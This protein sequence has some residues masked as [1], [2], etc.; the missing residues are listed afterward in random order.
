MLLYNQTQIIVCC[1]KKCARAIGPKIVVSITLLKKY[2]VSST[3][4]MYKQWL[5]W[6]NCTCVTI[7]KIF[8]FYQG[9]SQWGAV[10]GESETVRES[11]WTV[12]VV[13]DY[14]ETKQ[15]AALTN[16]KTKPNKA[17][18]PSLHFEFSPIRLLSLSDS[19]KLLPKALKDSARFI[20]PL[21]CVLIGTLL[22]S[23]CGHHISFTN[24]KTKTNKVSLPR[25]HFD[26]LFQVYQAGT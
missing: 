12:G 21:G 25:L 8:K 23:G 15:S 10:S 7:F 18:L 5:L 22:Y 17:Y 6:N 19:I 13:L 26:F 14:R 9:I 2:W 20:S 11:F 3:V 1:F 16:V 24:D 4:S